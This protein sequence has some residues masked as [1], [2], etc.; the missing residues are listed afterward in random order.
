MRNKNSRDLGLLGDVGWLSEQPD[1]FRLRIAGLGR[2]LAVPRGKIL[3]SVGDAPDAIYAVGEGMIDISVPIDAEEQVTVYR[4]APGFWI[5]DG[6]LLADM[7]RLLT[8]SVPVD[9]LLF[10]VP[11]P[12]LARSL[13]AFPGDW[14]YIHRLS[15]QNGA[16]SVRMLAEALVLSPKARFARLLLRL[17]LADGSV[18]TTQEDL[19][20]LAGMSRAAFR[21]T[22]SALIE[23]G[24]VETGR[25]RI[26]IRDR[27][28]LEAE[29]GKVWE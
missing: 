20:K 27:A 14:K 5:G 29:A 16:L 21:R 1:D 8:V 11:G 9:S 18:E 25:G 15:G 2:W 28:A 3:Y 17:S 24:A 7:P 12:A 6:S 23:S 10:R 4:A 13:E 19:G 22:F 26:R